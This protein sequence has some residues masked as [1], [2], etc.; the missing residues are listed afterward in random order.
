MQLGTH[1]LKGVR[2]NQKLCNMSDMGLPLKRIPTR[3]V[4]YPSGGSVRFPGGP[5]GVGEGGFIKPEEVATT[6]TH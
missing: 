5:V 6:R 3:L 2:R 1:L 4:A